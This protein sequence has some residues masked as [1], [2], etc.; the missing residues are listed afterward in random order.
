MPPR[1]API[2]ADATNAELFANTLT[3]EGK[4]INIFGTLAHH[5]KLMDRFNRMGGFLLNRGLIP[6]RE[7]EIVI[8]RIGWNSQS[9]Y[10]FGQHTIIGERV[11]LS[12]EEVRALTNSV[13]DG[14]WSSDDAALVELADNLCRDNVVSDVT[15]TKLR[16]RWNEAELV[17]LV[18]V[19][20]F[21][22]MVSGF[23]N[24]MGVELDPGVPTWPA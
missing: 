23:L 9:V 6:A 19:A 21:Y 11:G 22:R 14:P 15:W 2:V 13:S 7:R 8:L 17:E 18:I 5:P 3:V 4:P 1:I 20:G 10:E 16:A 24:T 12:S